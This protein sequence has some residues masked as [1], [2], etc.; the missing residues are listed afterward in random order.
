LNL[1]HKKICKK[2]NWQLQKPLVVSSA[3][4]AVSTHTEKGTDM[5]A[6]MVRDMHIT[7]ELDM[8]LDL[9]MNRDT[10]TLTH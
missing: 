9:E 3:C 1:I 10:D 2:I 7:M 6:E 8:N 4:F 5:V